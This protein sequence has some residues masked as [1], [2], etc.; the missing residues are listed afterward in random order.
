MRIDPQFVQGLVGALN[1]TTANEQQYSTEMSTGVT[2]NTLSDNP[3]AAGQDYLLRTSESVNDNF[4]QTAGGVQSM[5]QVTDTALGSVVTQITQ[6]ISLATEGNNGTLNAGN[7]QS[8]SNQLTGIQ[9]EIMS[10]AN[11]SYQGQYLF[12]GSQTGAAPFSLNPSTTP[13][14][15]VYSGDSVQETLQSPTGQTFVTNLPGDQVFGSGSSGILATL[16]SLIANFS[17]GASSAATVADTNAL[18]TDLQNVSNQR[19]VIDNSLSALQSSSTYLQSQTTQLQAAQD[20]LIQTNTA[21]V[22]SQLSAT[23]TQQTALVDMIGSLDQQGTLFDV[24]K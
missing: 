6:A 12:S 9:S 10:L 20:T 7:L 3:V 11:S 24:L 1:Q 15:V 18:T 5:L 16:S 4:V 8:V 21:Q 2:L 23:E 13:A 17:S 14:A 22:A 19:V